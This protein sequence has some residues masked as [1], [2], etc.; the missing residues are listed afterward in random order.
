VSDELLFVSIAR[1]L[2]LFVVFVA[3]VYVA[4]ANVEPVEIVYLPATGVQGAWA[5]RSVELPLF[6]VVLAAL[7]L[8]AVIG[9]LT[10]LYEQGRLRLALRRA[11]RDQRET[12]AKLT[13]AQ[14]GWEQEQVTT[15]ALRAELTALR[16]TATPP[17]EQAGVSEPR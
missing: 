12:S 11:L 4:S 15:H 2:A 8:G 17:K 5:A 3:A 7:V 16:A 1:N 6:V 13:I 9:G 10:A 14:E